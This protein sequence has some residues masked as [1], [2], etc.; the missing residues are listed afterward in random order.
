MLAL[1]C[2]CCGVLA[3][4]TELAPGGEAHLRRAGPES[5]DADFEAYMF[6]RQNP[7]GVHV[8][9]WRHA[10]GCGRWFHAVRDTVT[11]EVFG[12]YEAQTTEPPDE[13]RARIEER[14]A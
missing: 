5:D 3:D 2:P 9:R 4:E 6:L 11:M 13:I 12:T 14:Q 10:F 8:E 1:R 7:R